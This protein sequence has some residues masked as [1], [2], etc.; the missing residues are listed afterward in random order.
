M[1]GY[2][3]A[4]GIEGAIAHLAATYNSVCQLVAL[5]EPSIEHRVI[6]ALKIAHG[7]GA[8][9]R[10]VLLIGGVH[11]RE[12]VN[13]DLLVSFAT[14][15]LQAYTT[16]TGLTFGAVAYDA[17]LVQL[18]VN[19]LDL[20]ICPLVNPDGRVFVQSAGGDPMWRKN[21][22]PNAGLPCP[23][24]DINRNYDFLWSSGIGTSASAC[25]D[26]FKGPAA[27]SEP[28]TRNVR[29]LLDAHPNIVAMADIHSYSQLVLYPWGDDDNQSTNPAM[30]FHNPVYDGQRGTHGTGYG[31]Y[32]DTSD[33]SWFA[34]T[35]TAVRDA[36]A[37][38]RG[39]G[40][41]VE[42]GILLY[43][44]SA[45]VHDYAYSRHLVDATKPKVFGY[46]IETGTEFQPPWTE[47]A[48]II[49]EVC[50]G[51]VVFCRTILCAADVVF[52]GTSAAQHLDSLRALRDKV[53]AGSRAG[54]RF[55][56]LF[57]Q[58][59]AEVATILG[60]D[61]ALHSGAIDLLERWAEGAAAGG[62]LASAKVPSAIVK[63]AIALVAGIAKGASPALRKASTQLRRDL[64]AFSDV[65]V[66]AG[67]AALSKKR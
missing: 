59:G 15:L 37:A 49:D 44:T 17:T 62:G 26:V 16:N 12:V 53:L 61:K 42:Q 30:N 55:V 46:T 22:D 20:I 50:S 33:A 8:D 23:G 38:V 39:R 28:E 41:T 43:P 35:G 4:D 11:A 45:T 54:S 58:H 65:T 13:P 18:I 25:Q 34:T 63:Q 9:R 6:H 14:R 27:F 36:I 57:D 52:A 1:P 48:Q 56:A 47:A 10:G 3:T 31:E 29:H 32:I 7:A 40:Y 2:L 64:A 67:L 60:R 24:V 5:P 21:R 19:S 66:P 51:L